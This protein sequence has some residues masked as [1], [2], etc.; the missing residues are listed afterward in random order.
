MTSDQILRHRLALSYELARRESR[1]S[2]LAYLDRVVIDSRPEPRRFGLVARDWQWRLYRP[3][4]PALRAICGHTPPYGGPRCFWRTLPRGHDKTSH[5]ARLANYGISF[6]ARPVEIVVAAGDSDQAELLKEAMQREAE[7]NPWFGRALKFHRKR[8][9]GPSGVVKINTADAPTSFGLRAGIYVC[10]EITHW[11]KPDLWTALWSGRDKVPG[12]MFVVLTNAG[13]LGSWQ[14]DLLVEAQ[15]DPVTWDVYEAPG[16]LNS[17]MSPEEI[18]KTRRMLPPAEARRLFDNNWIDPAEECG[19]LTRAELLA[20]EEL[21]AEKGLVFQARGITGQCYV[22]SIDYG[23]KRDRTAL[24]VAHQDT[25]TGHVH[26]DR[27][28]VWQG[29]PEAP[30]L[31]SKVR[32][33]LDGVITNFRPLWLVVDP[34]QMEELIQDYSRRLPVERFESRGGKANYEMAE[35]FRS[36]IVNRQIAWYPGAGGLPVGGKAETLVDEVAGL[37]TKQMAYG[38]RV[39]HES[40]KHDDRFSALGMAC[41][42]LLHRPRPASW[43]AP[44][45]PAPDK[46]APRPILGGEAPA[47][48][49]W[50]RPS[51]REERKTRGRVVFGPG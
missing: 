39:D 6:A 45:P 31:I 43:T 36:L 26:V 28:E 10:D 14:H 3:V 7:L 38:Y 25:T 32:E 20:C 19:Y 12:A 34:Y 37:V 21:G 18:E 16:Q 49:D 1:G 41:V 48:D 11:A 47:G 2:P 46:A 24:C 15:R 30:V 33:W 27:L 42:T 51:R 22:A 23:P 5:L 13:M 35:L 9:Y 17:W 40:T 29:S 50:E 44:R 4:V 8:V